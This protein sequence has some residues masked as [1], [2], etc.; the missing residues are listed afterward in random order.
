MHCCKVLLRNTHNVANLLGGHSVLWVAI[1]LR[2]AR[3]HL[4][5]NNLIAILANEVNLAEL[6]PELT[7]EHL[8]T[9]GGKRIGGKPLSLV[10]ENLTLIHIISCDAQEDTDPVLG[11]TATARAS[12]ARRV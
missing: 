10:A 6:I 8:Q 3:L 2:L 12:W 1:R 7:M 5:K 9:L 4:Y 11:A